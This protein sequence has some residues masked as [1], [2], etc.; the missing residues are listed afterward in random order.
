VT[1]LSNRSPPT[2]ASNFNLYS[3]CPVLS[4]SA[5]SLVALPFRE[6]ERMS[7]CWECGWRSLGGDEGRCGSVLDS[8][9]YDVLEAEVE[10]MDIEDR[11]ILD[12][13]PCCSSSDCSGSSLK[14][15]LDE[16]LLVP[17]NNGLGTGE[18][19]ILMLGSDRACCHGE[20][21]RGDS[22]VYRRSPIMP[23]ICVYD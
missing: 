16:A 7:D 1:S 3:I 20:G 9:M 4:L 2:L 15:I 21:Y 14:G 23:G 12:M 13:P 6:G 5:T 10:D 19:L 18:T 8:E 11:D 17:I 22:P